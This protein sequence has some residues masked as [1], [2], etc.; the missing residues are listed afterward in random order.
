MPLA[1]V[2]EVAKEILASKSRDAEKVMAGFAWAVPAEAIVAAA[3]PFAVLCY[4]VPPLVERMADKKWKNKVAALQWVPK[5]V[6]RLAGSPAFGRAI[7]QIVPLVTKGCKDVRGEVRDA[8]SA[9]LNSV[10][11]RIA[12]PEMANIVP[13]LFK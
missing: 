4:C 8:A 11:S 6:E 1:D 5:V 13:T 10:F 7:P 12:N 9:A 3:G 2:M